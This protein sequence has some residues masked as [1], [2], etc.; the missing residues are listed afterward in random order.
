MSIKHEDVKNLESAEDLFKDYVSGSSPNGSMPK[1]V[2][3]CLRHAFFSGIAMWSDTYHNVVVS[4]D[5]DNRE[6]IENF[7]SKTQEDMKAF[8][9]DYEQSKE[10]REARGYAH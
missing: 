8:F 4:M 6:A 2:E 10:V 1:E 7:I 3:Q 5:E 9:D